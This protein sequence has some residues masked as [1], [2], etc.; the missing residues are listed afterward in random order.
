MPAQVLL[1]GHGHCRPP[2]SKT[3]IA[4]SPVDWS[5]ARNLLHHIGRRPASRWH[6]K[7][8]QEICDH[9]PLGPA[10]TTGRQCP[11]YQ[12]NPPFRAGEGAVLLSKGRRRKDYVS[13][14]SRLCREDVTD[15]QELQGLQSL[16]DPISVGVAHHWILAD[17]EEAFNSA[18]F[19]RVYHLVKES[20][21]DSLEAAWTRPCS[22]LLARLCYAL[23]S[24][25]EVGQG[26]HIA[27]SLNVLVSAEGIHACA[28]PAYIPR[29]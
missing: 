26:S 21:P 15:H 16:L 10:L 17:Y 8:G 14:L 18:L 12:L 4:D 25:V 29:G 19:C 23:V 3:V 5:E 20:A 2:A 28:F 1:E 7:P 24:R 11:A 9:N 6:A 13:Q 27:S 22:N